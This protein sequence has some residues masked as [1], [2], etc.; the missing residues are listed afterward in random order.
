V[1]QAAGVTWSPHTWSTG[2]GLVA[3]LQVALALSDGEYLEM[4]LDPP[5]WTPQRRD[6]MLPIPLEVDD[7]GCL[8]APPGP[9]LG[10]DPDLAAIERWRV[11]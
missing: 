3:N 6:F 11:G 8:V 5:A 2:Y 10:V 1:A 9:G 7:S 4:P